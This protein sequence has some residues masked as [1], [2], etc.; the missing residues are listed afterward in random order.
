MVYNSILFHGT[1]S[2][3]LANIKFTVYVLKLSYLIPFQ[4]T[5]F[6]Q[7]FQPLKP[8][9]NPF[10]TIFNPFINW[11]W[12]ISVITVNSIKSSIVL[13]ENLCLVWWISSYATISVRKS[14]N[15]LLSVNHTIKRSLS[16]LSFWNNS[17]SCW[18][19]RPEVFFEKVVLWNC[20]G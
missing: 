14:A 18:N 9:H 11:C 2:K 17:S 5:L 12:G 1:L 20:F 8:V 3:N 16:W 4:I 15:T 7:A 10:I 13:S 19:N 6:N